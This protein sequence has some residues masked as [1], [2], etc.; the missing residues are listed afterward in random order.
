[1]AED[2][3]IDLNDDAHADAAMRA[4]FAGADRPPMADER[5]TKSVMAQIEADASNKRQ[6]RLA[7]GVGL[8]SVAG[9][10]AFPYLTT[11]VVGMGAADAVAAF[12]QVGQSIPYV[13]ATG[14]AAALLG[15]IGLAGWVVASDR[16]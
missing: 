13:G 8:A 15:A 2:R 16:G 6:W 1:M 11:G 3:K 14:L 12:N 7:L 9:A 4:L 10:L 5:F